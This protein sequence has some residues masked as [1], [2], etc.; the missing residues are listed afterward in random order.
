MGILEFNIRDNAEL[1]LTQQDLSLIVGEVLGA[2]EVVRRLGA[3]GGAA[4]IGQAPGYVDHLAQN[5]P[6]PFNPTTTIA[7]S[8]GQDSRVNLSIY[9]VRGQLVKTIVDGFQQ[10][11]NYRVVWDGLGNQGAPVA[12]GAYFYKLEAGQFRA[13][14]KLVLLK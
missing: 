5:Y 11:R 13:T 14:K 4:S 6:N 3:A 7:Y 12:S 1:I 2:D 9:N 10:A 8:I